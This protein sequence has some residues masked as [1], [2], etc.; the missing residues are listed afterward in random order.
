MST[1]LD[2]AA[3]TE[4][5]P[6]GEH[7][8]TCRGISGTE[9]IGL[10]TRFPGLGRA[11]WDRGAALGGEGGFNASGL[12]A[13]APDAIATILAIGTEGKGDEYVEAAGRLPLEYQVELLAAILRC[14]LPGGFAPFMEKINLMF[15][16][17]VVVV[18]RLPRTGSEDARPAPPNGRADPAT[19][20][21]SA[22]N[23]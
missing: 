6:I 5:V 8:I 19:A 14:T 15:G 11:I 18:Q 23:G 1:L 21:P 10:L 4:T 17:A 3:I 20:L 13:A 7:T 22:S 16:E 9:L 12:A 2:I